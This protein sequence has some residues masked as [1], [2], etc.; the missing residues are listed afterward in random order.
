RR[1]PAVYPGSP[2]PV[3]LGFVGDVTGFNL[4]FLET[5]WAAHHVPVIACLGAD[6]TGGVYNINGNMV[7]NQ[8][9]AALGAERLFLVTS[10]PGVLRDIKDPASRLA[11]L[12][13]AEAR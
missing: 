10:T 6:A 9:A 8:L 13:C 11:R 4:G 7:G 5:L 12:T 1:P 3:D 2:D